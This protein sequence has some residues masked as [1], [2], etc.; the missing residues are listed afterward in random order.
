MKRGWQ[1]ELFGQLH[2]LYI[3]GG[4]VYVLLLEGQKIWRRMNSEKDFSLTSKVREQS[5]ARKR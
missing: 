1:N 3:Y 2:Y 4:K 5:L